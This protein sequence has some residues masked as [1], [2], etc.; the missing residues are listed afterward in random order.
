MNF[1]PYATD[2]SMKQIIQTPPGVTSPYRKISK[3]I[4]WLTRWMQ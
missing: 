3:C 1:R 2:N 4:D